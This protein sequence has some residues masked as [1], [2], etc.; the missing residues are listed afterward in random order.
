MK[1]ILIVISLFISLTLFSQASPHLPPSKGVPVG[2][3]GEKGVAVV[4]L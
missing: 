4:I 3:E 1:N 2:K